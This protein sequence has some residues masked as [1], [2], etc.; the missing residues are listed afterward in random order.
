[1]ACLVFLMKGVQDVPEAVA[2]LEQHGVNGNHEVQGVNRSDDV[3]M[4]VPDTSG[5]AVPGICAFSA[6]PSEFLSEGPLVS[7]SPQL[8]DQ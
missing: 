5:L 3:R 7:Y 6:A 8:F 2:G 4:V 1:M